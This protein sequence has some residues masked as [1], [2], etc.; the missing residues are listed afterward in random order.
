MH[1]R[2]ATPGRGA[3]EPKSA[4]TTL[5]DYFQDR[6]FRRSWS[7]A[8]QDGIIGTA[9]ILLG[10]TGA[11]AS[12][13]TLLVAVTT[14]TVA[15]M[16]T[17]GGA[18]WSETAAERE[19]QLR[20]ISQERSEFKSQRGVERAVLVGYYTDKGLSHDLADKVAGEL[21]LRNPLKAGLESEHGI[22]SLTSRGEVVFSGLSASVAY[23][24]GA[25]IPFGIAYFLPVEIEI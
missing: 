11:G 4:V 22:F 17:T 23:A 5:N 21:M 20:A 13:A 1:R 7:L 15:G 3:H 25:A 18:K 10:L 24:L 14:A 19:A 2:T 6:Q 8:S 16:L 9:G 12:E